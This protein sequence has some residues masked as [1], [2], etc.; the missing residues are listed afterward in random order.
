MIKTDSWNVGASNISTFIIS[1][2]PKLRERPTEKMHVNVSDIFIKFETTLNIFFVNHLIVL[3][4]QNI[5]Y[6]LIY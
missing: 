6:K 4:S 3:K 5:F 1:I 2:P